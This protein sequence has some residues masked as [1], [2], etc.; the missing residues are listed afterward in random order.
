MSWVRGRSVPS[1]TPATSPS[2]PVS[3]DVS[4]AARVPAPSGADVLR[5]SWAEGS[6]GCG[7]AFAS[8]W[9]VP[10]VDAVVDAIDGNRDAW[11]AAERLGRERASAGV[12]L[13]EVLTDVDVLTGLVA[14]R[15]REVLVRAVSLGWAEASA[16]P[17]DAVSDALT[18]LA[19]AEYL[20]I[21]LGEI[22][23]AAEVE[24]SSAAHSHALV[25]VRLGESGPY[26]WTQG[27]PMI[28]VGDALRTVFDAGESL[29][30]IGQSVGVALAPREDMLA[31][32]ARLLAELIAARVAVSDT[33][34]DLLPQVWIE[35]LP[36]SWSAAVT[37]LAELTR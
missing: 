15:H 7:W 28:L 33:D 25:V 17:A 29:A 22:Y 6:Q 20:R 36:D 21:R 3:G 2:G 11:A 5:H 37:L 13:A 9:D 24:G 12:P 35:G 4:S 10:A 32:R 18:G 23:R 34:V 27:L 14:P 1:A 19:S 26:S 16:A 30:R 8:D 31:R